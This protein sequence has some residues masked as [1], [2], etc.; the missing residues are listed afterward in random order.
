M[1]KEYTC[2]IRSENIKHIS[3]TSTTLHVVIYIHLYIHFNHNQIRTV[4]MVTNSL[5]IIIIE[6]VL[7]HS[8]TDGISNFPF[9]LK[10]IIFPK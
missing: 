2:Y 7:F 4:I 1:D 8:K 3:I 10:V 9:I 5:N 6:I